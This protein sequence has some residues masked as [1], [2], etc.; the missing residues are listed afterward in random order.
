M[1]QNVAYRPTVYRT[2]V[3]AVLFGPGLYQLASKFTNSND[4]NIPFLINML[5]V[6]TSRKMGS[7]SFE[8]IF[9]FLAHSVVAVHSAVA[10]LVPA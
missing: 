9:G 3:V 2:G 10:A 7:R 4:N 1:L 8:I 5:C 6:L